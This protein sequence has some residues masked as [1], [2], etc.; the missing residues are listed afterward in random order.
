MHRQQAALL[1]PFYA[2]TQVIAADDE[3]LHLFHS[4]YRAQDD[5]LLATAEQML[6]HVDARGG[7]VCPANPEMAARARALA[8][9]QAA[10][11]R[12]E[13]AGRSV[14]QRQS[15]GS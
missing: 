5:T 12:P 1:E 8:A 15:H 11:P 3:R 4:L 14:G 6:L 7:R 9:T 10:L 13:Q 2:T